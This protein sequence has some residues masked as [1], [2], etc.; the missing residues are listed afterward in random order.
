MLYAAFSSSPPHTAC[1]APSSLSLPLPSSHIKILL[2]LCT[3][4]RC[5][6]FYSEYGF[7]LP[8]LWTQYNKTQNINN[9]ALFCLLQPCCK[10]E[11]N[12]GCRYRANIRTGIL[13]YYWI[14]TCLI[15]TV[16]W[17]LPIMTMSQRCRSWGYWHYKNNHQQYSSREYLLCSPA[18][19]L[20][21]I[22]RLFLR[23]R[24][25]MVLWLLV[26]I[27]A[28]GLEEIPVSTSLH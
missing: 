17:W 8:G 15:K 20:R 13:K 12:T 25:N 27:G 2:R 3:V 4:A 22:S 19:R 14:I 6:L 24:R 1:L 26:S 18:G 11:P 9:S 16:W 7:S 23:R 21:G 5:S 28:R 10:N